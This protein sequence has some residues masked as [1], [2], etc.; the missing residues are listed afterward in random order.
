ML[1]IHLHLDH[2]SG[3]FPS[4]FPTNNIYTV[5]FSDI[6]ATFPAYFILL[7]L[8]ILIL[9]GEEYKLNLKFTTGPSSETDG[10]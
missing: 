8:T 10:Y 5:L 3:L 4:G 9:L 7:D 6:R 2:P 1:S